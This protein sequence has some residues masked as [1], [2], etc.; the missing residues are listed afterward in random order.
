MENTFRSMQHCI[1]D[2]PKSFSEML[3][4]VKIVPT[5]SEIDLCDKN[6]THFT[7]VIFFFLLD[8]KCQLSPNREG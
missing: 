8:V 6:Q 7:I 2:S 4:S 5:S 3:I 1:I